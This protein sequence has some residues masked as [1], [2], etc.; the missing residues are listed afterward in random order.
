MNVML[1]IYYNKTKKIK[2]YKIMKK[3]TLKH[4]IFP[5]PKQWQI[6]EIIP[7]S[8]LSKMIKSLIRVDKKQRK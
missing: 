6:G 2:I 8:K 7:F 1:K 5:L 4:K 3:S